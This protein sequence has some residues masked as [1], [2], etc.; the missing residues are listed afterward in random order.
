MKAFPELCR[1]AFY[2][3]FLI[4]VSLSS[5]FILHWLQLLCQ[6]FT[7]LLVPSWA[8]SPQ[9]F[10]PVI[11]KK[12]T[13]CV[14]SKFCFLWHKS[15]SRLFTCTNPSLNLLQADV[16]QCT[17]YFCNNSS[18]PFSFDFWLDGDENSFCG[19]SF[20]ICQLPFHPFRFLPGS[21]Y[22]HRLFF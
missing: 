3:I 22:T 10:C 11:T 1:Y 18:L 21:P 14:F 12:C 17:F 6:W 4:G 16:V 5:I 13:L 8:V 2:V 20:C 19:L 7:L 15:S 9:S